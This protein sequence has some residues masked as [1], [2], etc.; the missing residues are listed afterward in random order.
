M[1]TAK[2]KTNNNKPIPDSSTKTARG[3]KKV[4][5]EL[6]RSKEDGFKATYTR[7]EEEE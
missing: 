5:S 7:R 4:H 3:S 6:D 1:D 2:S